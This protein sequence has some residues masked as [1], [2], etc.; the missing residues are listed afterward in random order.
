M[1]RNAARTTMAADSFLS[2]PAVRITLAYLALAS[3]WIL[4]S[5][6]VLGLLLGTTPH[7]YDAQTI[8]GLA[9]VAV[10]GVLLFLALRHVSRSGE[11][12][13][14]LPTPPRTWVPVV[15][16]V[17]FALGLIATGIFLFQ[18]QRRQIREFSEAQLRSVGE[19]RVEQIDHWLQ[20]TRANAH[21]FGH[22]SHIADSYANWLAGG[23]TA[24]TEQAHL[25][26]HLQE[27]RKS[28][29]YAGITLYDT[30]GNPRLSDQAEPDMGIHR[31][32]VLHT[33]ATGQTQLV[34]IHG[35][36]NGRE[37]V[38]GLI[39]PI[40]RAGQKQVSGAVFISIQAR[41]GLF[42]SLAHW[43]TPA[44]SGETVLLRRQ[45]NT[46]QLLFASRL[47]EHE[48]QDKQSGTVLTHTAAQRVFAGERGFLDHARDYRGVPVLAYAQNLAGTPWILV[49]KLDQNEVEAPLYR[50]A[51]ATGLIT[52]L[53]L[54]ATALAIQLW[55]RSQANRHHTQLLLKELEHQML[56]SRYDTLSRHA[57]DTILLTDTE[58]IILEANERVEH[59]YGYRQ[60]ELVGRSGLLLLPPDSEDAAFKR[61]DELLTRGHLRFE[62]VHLRRDGKRFNVE[63]SAHII[64]V[65]GRYQ[66]H[67]TIHDITERKT[68]ADALALSNTR[69]LEA[70]RLAGM[71]DW[72][73]EV[74]SGRD[75]CS[76]Q[77][78]TIT[79][80]DPAAGSPDFTTLL[81]LFHPDDI[82]VF[83]RDTDLAL[84]D[85]TPYRHEL[86]ILRPDG[87]VRHVW[88]HG[89]AERDE[90]GRVV[91]LYGTLQDISER[92]FN[93]ARL[94]LALHHDPLT[95][96]PNARSLLNRVQQ[97]IAAG[98]QRLALLVLNID[99]FSQLNESLG[100]AAGD[101]VLTELALRWAAALPENALLAR[102]DADQFAVFWHETQV[103]AREDS[104]TLL[105]IIELANSLLAAMALPI[106]FS[107]QLVTLSLSIGISVYPG[108][109]EDAASLLHAGE[110]AMRLAKAEKGNQVRF[111]D[112]R[113]A[114]TAIDWFETETALRQA[115]ERDELFLD[116]QPQVDTASGRIV[117]A[118]ALIRWRHN[119]TVIPPGRFIHVVEGTD[120]AEPV[121]RWV[122]LSACRQARQWM[123]RYHPARVA[124][125]IFSDHVTSGHLLDDV[126][127]ALATSGLPPELLE[128][129]V[130]ES[131]LLKNPEMA[132]RSLREVKRL[133]V[134]LALDDFGT[135]YSSLGYL[136]HYPFDV[137]KIDQLFSRN[138]TR[139]PEDAAIVRSTIALAHN[140]GMRVLA[141]GVETEPQLR[142][143]ARYGCDQIQGYLTSRPTTPDQ[144][145]I[146]VMQRS[147]LRP[148]SLSR[149]TQTAH[150][151]IVEDEAI[152]A[153]QLRMVL[154]DEGYHTHLAENLDSALAVMG[155]ERIDLI[156]SDHYLRGSTG[157]DILER[158]RRLFPDVPRI[159]VSGAEEQSVVVE[160]VNRAGIRAFLAKPV[161]VTALLHE[162]RSLLAEASHG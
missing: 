60:D 77:I 72:E 97:V 35:H 36:S 20:T 65:Q 132:A 101:R 128:L 19:L 161:D 82:E 134:S 111:F 84:Q 32:A 41:A 99:R 124:V 127:S 33:I 69:L 15:T 135:G 13:S 47:Q 9:F 141:E 86:K 63:V 110:D 62:S 50:L 112:R 152:E 53:L 42:I 46:L 12:H 2:R 118:E 43:P 66:A 146:R 122:L 57:S 34:D 55:W 155:R 81:N 106:E 28:Y 73:Y 113:H 26:Q 150:V 121:S 96:L 48:I 100:R 160:A 93:E 102:L 3:L 1:R 10:T 68:A 4:A 5:D 29:G 156:I 139:D 30:Q 6:S 18:D 149:P 125:N 38:L 49:T 31:D 8:K 114:Q 89:R 109:A 14:R 133:G 37:P 88:S 123:D 52:S 95:G 151:L 90:S 71:G 83:K 7:N 130:L 58:G 92:R 51:R 54:L 24:A 148:A 117:A 147:D 85:G 59:M 39:A 158:M 142:F 44:S 103:P 115:L 16:F 22:A 74:A 145:E 79:G 104:E 144:V 76:E 67:L 64:N 131:S 80:L 137:L 40:Q 157:V 126:R 154:D 56:V 94:E 159:M 25:L 143:M 153:E 120:L 27:L 78:Y 87:Q 21:Y 11:R 45:E 107:G 23:K 119:G 116:Y 136:K 105:D 61:R 138:V 75:P 98:G 108:D 129:E 162:V 17:L 91:R 70:Q 140:L